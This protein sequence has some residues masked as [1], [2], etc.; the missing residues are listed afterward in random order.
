MRTTTY[1]AAELDAFVERLMRA[2]AGMLDID[3]A[4]LGDRLGLY[5]ALESGSSNRRL[6]ARCGWMIVVPRHTSAVTPCQP[7]TLK[8]W[9][10]A[11]ARTIWRRSRD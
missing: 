11:T 4:Y 8:S 7:A 6:S 1:I 9:L 5:R 10:T 3:T 2:T